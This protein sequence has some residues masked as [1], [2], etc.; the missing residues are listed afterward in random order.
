MPVLSMGAPRLRAISVA[1]LLAL[2]AGCATPPGHPA[3]EQADAAVE[4]ARRSPRVRALAAAELDRAEVALQDARSAARAGASP[5]RVEH[6]L[7]IVTQRAALAEARAAQQVARSEIEMLDRALVQVRPEQSRQR[8]ASFPARDQQP[9]ATVQLQARAPLA[10]NRLAQTPPQAPQQMRAPLQ[11]FRQAAAPVPEAQQADAWLPE[12][13]Q[14]GAQLQEPQQAALSAKEAPKPASAAQET[15]QADAP[16][17][18][19]RRAD[20]PV[21]AGR[22]A[23]TPLQE[24]WQVAVSARGALE[25][26]GAAHE[27]RRADTPLQEPRRADTPL[28]VPERVALSAE[29]AP[30]TAGAAQEAQQA[31]AP[32]QE[33]QQVRSSVEEA[34]T[35][36]V[37]VEE[38]WAVLG[39]VRTQDGAAAE[40]D[41]VGPDAAALP[42][43]LTLSL[44][45]LSFAGAEP[46]SETAERL[47]AVAEQLLRAPERRIAIEA[48]FNLPDPEARTVLEQRVE[49]VRAILLRSGVAPE[50][51]VVRA[52]GDGPAA[53]RAVSSS[54]EA[55]Y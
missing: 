10:E 5:D 22:P 24:P 35:D 9:R 28:Q 54:V 6:L 31:D 47:A 15:P 26:A 36:P 23:D 27:I 19:S 40:P 20:A 55:P 41:P 45:R 32:L 3:L 2:A 16:L 17:Q 48:E 51:V 53:R 33:L 39:P 11:Q 37:G 49:I 25:A 50:R 1:L 7:Y 42:E 46:T 13:R 29:E 14:T 18:Q 52:S 38:A 21:Q 43:E 34:G 12:A 8:R 30:E 4:R 44:A